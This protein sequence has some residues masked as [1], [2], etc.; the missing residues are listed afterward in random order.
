MK[1]NKEVAYTD[2]NRVGVFNLS[3][4]QQQDRE[5][6]SSLMQL[7]VVLEAFPHESGRGTTFICASKL[8][9]ELHEGEEIPEYRLEFD[10]PSRPLE[11]WARKECTKSGA[12]GW[13]AIRNIIVRVPPLNINMSPKV[14]H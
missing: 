9:Q 1:E 10:H 8:F 3:F 6:M 13:R 7:M 11:E 5:L 14:I 2:S 4:E 12:F